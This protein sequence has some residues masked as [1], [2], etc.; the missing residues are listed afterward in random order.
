MKTRGEPTDAAFY[1]V[2]LFSK[3]KERKEQRER[4][5]N[6]RT[7]KCSFFSISI[8]GKSEREGDGRRRRRPRG[9]NR[10]IELLHLLLKDWWQYSL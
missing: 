5:K 7:I 4:K 3:K 10:L 6:S 1:P 9:I 2:T 8:S